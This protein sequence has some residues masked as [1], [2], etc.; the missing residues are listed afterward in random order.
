MVHVFRQ[1]P[2][3]LILYAGLALGLIFDASMST[4]DAK[5]W[6]PGPGWRDSYAVGGVCYCDSSNYDHGI[7]TKIVTTPDG[8]E[9]SVRQICSDI[10][11]TIGVG[12]KSGR[13]P[14][15]TIA[16]GHGPANDAADEDL[17]SGCPGR[18]DMG[19]DGCFEIGPRWPLDR[20]YEL[21]LE[22]IKN[23]RWRFN[24]SHNV[25]ALGKLT[26]NNPETRWSTNQPQ[27]E[28]QWLEIDLGTVQAFNRIDLMTTR[29]PMDFPRA[30][31]IEASLDGKNWKQ[32]SVGESDMDLPNELTR[33]RLP[34]Q[35]S[36]HIRIT[37]TGSASKYY[38]SVHGLKVGMGL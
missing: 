25:M 31:K 27:S 18:V 13:I 1:F 8:Y 28:G 23:T 6:N 38:W 37:Q 11:Q 26:D 7:G 30:W 12:A 24:S 14:Y 19:S 20:V 4:A 15:N 22:N 29:S 21:R 34:I 33:L 10:Q 3:I 5:N 2:S 17:V 36:R 32:V 9:R 35:L 16:C